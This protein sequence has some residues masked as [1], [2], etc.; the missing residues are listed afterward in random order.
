MQAA[1]RAFYRQEQTL[2]LL[3]IVAALRYYA[4]VHDGKLP[5]SLADITELSVPKVCPLTAKPYEYR[6]EGNTAIIDYEAGWGKSRMEI[7]V[8]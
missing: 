4:A 2:D 5:A 6:V 3:R 7:T 8:E 1:R